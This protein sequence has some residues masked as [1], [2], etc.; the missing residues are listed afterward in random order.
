M[1]LF[2]PCSE[3]I[4]E[5]AAAISDF[6]LLDSPAMVIIN[7]PWVCAIWERETP[8]CPAQPLLALLVLEAY[9]LSSYVTYP[10]EIAIVSIGRGE[11]GG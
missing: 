11:Y 8:P 4:S 9:L 7:L 5:S 1:M 6:P 10:A 2:M 3:R